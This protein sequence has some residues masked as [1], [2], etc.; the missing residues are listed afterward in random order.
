MIIKNRTSKLNEIRQ[1]NVSYTNKMEEK[2]FINFVYNIN[3]STY[4]NII[5]II[6]IMK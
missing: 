1:N 6:I 3:L 4:L 2:K 5:I